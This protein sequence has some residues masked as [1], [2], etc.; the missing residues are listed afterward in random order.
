MSKRRTASDPR[1]FTP[2]N[3]PGAVSGAPS[4]TPASAPADT[5]RTVIAMIRALQGGELSGSNLGVGDRRRCVEHLSAEGY[6]VPEIAEILRVSERTIARDREAIKSANSVARDPKL[7]GEMVGH[8]LRQAEASVARMKRLG[9]DRETPP[10]VRLDAEK[11][12]WTVVRELTETLQSLGY[13][14]TAQQT[15]AAELTHR[16]ETEPDYAG[17]Q[18]ELERLEGILRTSAPAGSAAPVL[19]EILTTKQQVAG[20]A[21][22]AQVTALKSQVIE[23]QQG[24]PDAGPREP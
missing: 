10:V 5:D 6:V 7:V 15:I 16:F 13:L 17:M 14:P 23:S 12:C 9:R 21:A 1:A 4:A 20:L 11:A 3:D 2:A 18:Q 24:A 8:L 22:Q 19:V